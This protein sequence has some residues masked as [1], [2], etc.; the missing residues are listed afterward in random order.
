MSND[1]LEPDLETRRMI[2]RAKRDHLREQA[3]EHELNAVC[4]ETQG[5]MA[6]SKA[7][8][9]EYSRAVLKSLKS[10]RQLYASARKLNEL[11]EALPAPELPGDDN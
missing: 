7:E 1:Q 6:D 2:L 9:E 11:L 4:N 10:A 5:A 8:Q 3:F